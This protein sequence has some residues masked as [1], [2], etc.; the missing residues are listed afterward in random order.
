MA[1]RCRV[2]YSGSSGKAPTKR[3]IVCKRLHTVYNSSSAIENIFKIIRLDYVVG[4]NNGKTGLS[5][6]RLG[7]GG[8]IGGGI[9]MSNTGRNR[10]VNISL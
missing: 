1:L 8:V 5:G 3:S 6:F 9:K 7:L 4:Y 2:C 10:S